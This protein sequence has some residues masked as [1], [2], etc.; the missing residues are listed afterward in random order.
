MT[1]VDTQADGLSP[2]IREP[3]AQLCAATQSPE[4]RLQVKEA[5]LAAFDWIGEAP[6]ALPQSSVDVNF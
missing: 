4:R 1:Q 3:Q 6:L 2:A 5:M